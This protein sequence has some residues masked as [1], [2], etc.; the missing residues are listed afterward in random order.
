MKYRRAL[1]QNQSLPFCMCL[2]DS[3]LSSRVIAF[4]VTLLV[5]SFAPYLRAQMV[6]IGAQQIQTSSDSNAA[7]QAEAFKSTANAS[8]SVISLSIY[9]DT[10]SVAKKLAAGLYTDNGGKPG[11][12]LTQGSIN[13]PAAGAWNTI[14][15]PSTQV[16]SGAS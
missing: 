7:G 13:A 2:Q 3:R 1:K 11:T 8:G 15:V 14:P 16:T 9:V 6:I 10:G 5:A 4:F 12:L